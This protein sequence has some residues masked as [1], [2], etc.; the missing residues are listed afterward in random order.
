M[1]NSTAIAA[2]ATKLGRK[3]STSGMTAVTTTIKASDR[4]A[5]PGIKVDVR[6]G[7]KAPQRGSRNLKVE[8]GTRKSGFAHIVDKVLVTA[9]MFNTL[10]DEIMCTMHN[11]LGDEAI[12][13]G[14]ATVTT[15]PMGGMMSFETIHTTHRLVIRRRHISHDG[16][17]TVTKVQ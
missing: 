6:S 8:T 12:T 15:A 10:V 1:T 2:V 4:A 14:T 5:L 11:G 13:M 3:P 17:I 9:P 7:G 16:Q